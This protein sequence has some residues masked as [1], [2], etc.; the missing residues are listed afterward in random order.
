MSTTSRPNPDFSGLKDCTV[1]I[2]GAGG[3][4]GTHLIRSLEGFG[5]KVIATDRTGREGILSV[6]VTNESE[7]DAAFQRSIDL[8]QKPVQLVYHLAGQKSAALA[9]THPGETLR[10]AFDGTINVLEAAR[11]QAGL[12]KVV[13]FSSIAVYGLNDSQNESQRREPF[14][15]SDELRPDSIYASSKITGEF[16][17]ISYCRDLGLPVT[18][19]RLTNV[20]GPHQSELAII[21]SLMA[22]MKKGGS[23]SLG[24]LDAVR[25]FIYVEDAVEALLQLGLSDQTTGATFNVGTGIGTSIRALVAE[26]SKVLGFTGRIEV[27][28]SKVRA[29]EKKFAVADIQ[30]VTRATSWKPRISLEAGLKSTAKQA[31]G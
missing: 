2:T 10:T 19:A 8:Y 16:A 20:Y 1:L 6:D 28:P 14:R 12:R 18:V 23:L 21:P 17:G 4:I 11:R 26:L 7:V 15:E 31:Q 24:N 29:N 30:A 25:D 22:Q 9:R 5:A 3:F 27:D 13:L